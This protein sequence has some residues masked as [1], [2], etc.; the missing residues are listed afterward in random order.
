MPHRATVYAQLVQSEQLWSWAQLLPM[1]VGDRKLLPPPSMGRCAGAPSVCDI[2]LSQVPPDTFTALSPLCTM[3]RWVQPLCFCFQR[4]FVFLPLVSQQGT[5]GDGLPSLSCHYCVCPILS[6]LPV[7]MQRGLQPACQQCT[8][9]ILLPV[10]GPR[11]R[12][13]P[14]CSVLVGHR[15]GS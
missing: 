2:Q 11:Q 8:C 14:G 6:C 13:G 12:S 4:A 5:L 3:F 10:P 7:S 1:Q 9:V 15:H